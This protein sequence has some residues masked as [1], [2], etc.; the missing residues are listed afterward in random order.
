MM[1]QNGAYII[2][3]DQES[4]VVWGMPRFVVEVGIADEVVNLNEMTDTILSN[5][6]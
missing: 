3:Q 2:A 5:L 1:K 4:S 6:S